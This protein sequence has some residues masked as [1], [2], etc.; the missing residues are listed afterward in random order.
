MATNVVNLDALIPR[1]DFAVDEAPSKATPIDRINM[2]T[3]MDIFSQAIFANQI[4]NEKRR[5]GRQSKLSI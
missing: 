2:R 5:N 3:W 1:D 4:F